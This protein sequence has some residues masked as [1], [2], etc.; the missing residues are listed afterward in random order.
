MS[1]PR[2]SQ[3]DWIFAGF[4][5]LAELGPAA[6]KAEI[7]ARR[8]GS[9]K[10]SFYWHFSDVAS[11]HAAMMELWEQ[12][13]VTDIIVALAPLSDPRER[14]RA[15]VRTAIE[16]PAELDPSQPAE[17]AIRAW[18][19]ASPLVRETVDR[20][21]TR[22]MEYLETLLSDAGVPPKPNARLLYATLIGLD[23]L[24]GGQDQQPKALVHLTELILTQYPDPACMQPNL[25]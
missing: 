9:S 18:A 13:A 22:R 1:K 15:L 16:T 5:A 25:A 20:V 7:L 24:R 21:D 8:I 11:F 4:N 6:L 19:R 23:D 2:L 3:S 14:L 17:S 10:G 12:R